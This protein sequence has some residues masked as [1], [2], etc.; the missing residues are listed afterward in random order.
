MTDAVLATDPIEE[1][2]TVPAPEPVREHL[3]VVRQDRLGDPM[4]THREA[5]RIT[6][7]LRGR[8]RDDHTR[9]TQNRE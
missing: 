5:E 4:A 9:E 7:R 1:H 2:L 8:P 6:R 3:P